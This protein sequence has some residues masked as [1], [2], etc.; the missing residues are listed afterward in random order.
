VIIDLPDD[1]ARVNALLGG[2]IDAMTDLPPAQVQVV[3]RNPRTTVL[4]S[5]GAAWVPICMR[6]DRPPFD[7]VRVRRALRLIVDRPQ[8][9]RQALD[10]HGRVGNDLYALFDPAYDHGIPQ[11]VADVEQARALL[12]AAGRSDLT[13]ELVTTN[14]VVG[15]REGAQV[16]AEQAKAAGVTVNV[17]FLDPGAFYANYP[18]WPFCMAFWGTRNYLA[19]VAVAGL[20]TSLFNETRWP[21]RADRRFVALYE[22]ALGTADRAR[23]TALIH[24]MQTLEHQSGGYVVWGFNA[25]L[26]G[27]AVE[28]AGLRK[29]DRGTLPLNGFG[30]GYRTIWFG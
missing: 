25:W 9:I 11:R 24:E 16:F 23:R 8:M 7:D 15:M 1:T 20:P 4:E 10:G 6:I 21:D 2:Q 28:V 12:K 5:P 27:H 30:H 22:Q 19:Q 18:K 17:R 3:N 13:L 29:G 26:D 14:A